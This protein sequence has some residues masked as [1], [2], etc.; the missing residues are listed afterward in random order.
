MKLRSNAIDITGLRSGSLVAVEP[1]KRPGSRGVYWLCRCDCGN[2]AY[3]QGSHLRKGSRVSCGCKSKSH[4]IETAFNT[5]ISTYK[6]KSR[7]R[8][9]IFDLSDQE[10]K[11]LI[12]GTCAYCGIEPLQGWKKQRTKE[13]VLKYNG[14]DRIDSSRGYIKSNCVTACFK[15]NM[16]KGNMSVDEFKA[17]IKRMYQWL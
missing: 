14:I 6:T 7:A 8:K 17:H 9:R 15:C 10:F 2:N 12:F 11:E 5:L 1:T 4:T 16:A 13:V 3:A